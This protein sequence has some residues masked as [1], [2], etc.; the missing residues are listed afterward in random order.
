MTMTSH[1]TEPALFKTMGISLETPVRYTW[2]AFFEDIDG[3]PEFPPP[4]GMGETPMQA[5]RDLLQDCELVIEYD[6]GGERINAILFDVDLERIPQEMTNERVTAL[7]TIANLQ[8]EVRWDGEASTEL[9][10]SY[11]GRSCHSGGTQ[12]TYIFCPF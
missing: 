4:S 8:S 7:L 5:V 10:P 1:Q 11:E 3:D 2:L 9:C 6:R 12:A